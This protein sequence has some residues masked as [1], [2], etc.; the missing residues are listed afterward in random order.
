MPMCSDGSACGASHPS[1]V[2]CRCYH[3]LRTAAALRTGKT[4]R[5]LLGSLVG[6]NNERVPST[7][8]KHMADHMNAFAFG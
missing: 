2:L 8:A 1:A 4:V 5:R 7:I 3:D 6:N